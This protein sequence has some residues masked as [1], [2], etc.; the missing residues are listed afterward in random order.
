M[1][2]SQA[3]ISSAPNELS[4]ACK[5]LG[6]AEATVTEG[7]L[8]SITVTR[9]ETIR[10]PYLCEKVRV[11]LTGSFAP[12]H[13]RIRTARLGENTVMAPDHRLTMH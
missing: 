11:R 10:K 4:V 5:L 2:T 13:R 8:F 7:L 1:C 3:T 12:R 6:I 9:G